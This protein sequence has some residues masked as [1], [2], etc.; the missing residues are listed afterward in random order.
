MD[1]QSNRLCLRPAIPQI[2]LAAKYLDDAVS[3]HISGRPKLAADLIVA[4]NMP[5]IREW[6]ESL[7][8][9]ASPYVKF[10]FVPGAPAILSQAEREKLRMPNTAERQRLHARDGYHCRFCG[11]PVIRAEVRN[12][13]RELYPDALP[14][15]KTNMTQHPAFQTMWAQ[16]DHVLPHARGGDNDPSNVIITCAPCNFGRMNYTLE[17]VGLS[18]PRLREPVQPSWDGLE[19]LLL[20]RNKP[21]PIPVG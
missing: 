15:G 9:K 3:A 14:W 12:R 13:L 18:D 17:E 20:Y 2:A 5:A 19:R 16:Y 10:R 21:V 1:F 7:W 6:G 11:I 4:A 8:G